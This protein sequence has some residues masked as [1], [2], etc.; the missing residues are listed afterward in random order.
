[1]CE[2]FAGLAFFHCDFLLSLSFPFLFFF[3][4]A[5]VAEDSCTKNMH[6]DLSILF[7]VRIPLHA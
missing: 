3:F 7:Y 1:M 4:H 2:V 5:Q 6:D